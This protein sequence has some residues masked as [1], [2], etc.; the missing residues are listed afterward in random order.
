M[1]KVVGF[2][3][4][5]FD[6]TRDGKVEHITGYSIYV[7]SEISPRQGA[8][9]AVDKIY[10]SDR[11]LQSENLKVED[12]LNKNIKIYYNRYGKVSSVVVED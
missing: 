8:G 12:L 2:R 7:A 5:D 9:Y 11:K 3:R 1:V 6:V 10:M 4:A